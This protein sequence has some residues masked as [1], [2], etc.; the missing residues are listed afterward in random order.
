MNMKKKGL[1]IR[2]RGKKY[3]P[4]LRVGAISTFKP[5][6]RINLAY[7]IRETPNL[8]IR[9]NRVIHTLYCILYTIFMSYSFN[10]RMHRAG[11]REWV[12][13]MNL[14]RTVKRKWGPDMTELTL[15]GV[16]SQELKGWT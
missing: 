12:L 10:S 9:G 6:L 4:I 15:S 5:Y 1:D 13:E 2:I 11:K 7:G 14:K 16:E 8:S 3:I